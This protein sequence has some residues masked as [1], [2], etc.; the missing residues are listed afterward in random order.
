MPQ[1]R[2]FNNFIKEFDLVDLPLKGTSFTWSN[3]QDRR[4]CSR[5]D[6]FLF[7]IDWMD[8]APLFSQEVLPNPTSDHSPII[9]KIEDFLSGPRPFR[10]ELM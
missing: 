3:N 4:V 6:R 10:F 7:S 5:L 1:M 8:Q 2:M 9:L